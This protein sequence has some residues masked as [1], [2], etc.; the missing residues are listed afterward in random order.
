[1]LDCR[2]NNVQVCLSRL[3]KLL[4]IMCICALYSRLS[5]SRKE[6]FIAVL[7]IAISVILVILFNILYNSSETYASD[8]YEIKYDIHINFSDYG[9]KHCKA[10]SFMHIIGPSR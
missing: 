9:I 3:H 6:H 10:D 5:A 2:R 8:I 4:N 7:I 1:M